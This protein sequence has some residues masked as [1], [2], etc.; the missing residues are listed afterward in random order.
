MAMKKR[1]FV[2][3][4]LVLVMSMV[5]TACS[6][7]GGGPDETTANNAGGTEQETT[8]KE[9]DITT[10]GTGT[11]SETKESTTKEEE[12]TQP[13]ECK[14][15]K[16]ELKNAKA[17]T[18]ID[19]G[20]SGDTVCTACG[21]V[22]SKGTELALSGH[23]Y[24]AGAILKEPTCLEKGSK[25][26]TCAV[27]K[28]TKT[29]EIAI[30]D[31][32][33][34]YHFESDSNHKLVC[35]FC[36]RTENGAHKNGGLVSKHE[37]T[38]D[39]EAYSVYKC[40]DCAHE[41]RV[42]DGP[43]KGH[44]WDTANPV[45][46]DPTCKD[47]G[48]M[49]FNCLNGC[50]EKGSV[51]VLPATPTVHS[52][53][54]V[55]R[56]DATCTHEGEISLVCE[57]CDMPSIVAIPKIPHTYGDAAVVDG[58]SEKTCKSC[59]HKV[60]SFDAK[61]KTDAKV[62]T[63]KL[64][65]DQAF[66]VELK[67]AQIEFPKEIVEQL[68]ENADVTVGA[69]FADKSS[70]LQSG[71]Y[72]ED[73][74]K[75][76][77]NEKSKIYDFTVDGIDTSDFAK[78]VT[79]TLPYTLGEN[80]DPE[81]IVIWY[82]DTSGEIV[83]VE[84][85]SFID[86]DGDGVGEVMFEVGHFSYYAIAYRE[87]PEMRCRRGV[88][89]YG[90]EKDWTIIP[91]S[92]ISHGYTVKTCGT[93]GHTNVDNVK[94][95]IAHNW[96]EKITPVVDCE[97]GGYVHQVCSM[98]YSVK[99]YEYI[100][101]KGHTPAGHAT[102]DT[103]VFCST[104]NKTIVSAYG[105]K[106]TEWETIIEPGNGTYG[107]RRRN[108]TRCGKIEQED[109]APKTD[110]KPWELNS[111]SDLIEV[112]LDEVIAED[113]GTITAKI[114][115]QGAEF[116]INV[117]FDKSG[118]K[119]KAVI[120]IDNSETKMTFYYFDGDFYIAN[121]EETIVTDINGMTSVSFED[122]MKTVGLAIDAVDGVYQDV[123]DGL[124]SFVEIL[125]GAY[126]EEIDKILADSG[127]KY[128]SESLAEAVEAI[129]SVY[130]Y[131][132]IKLGFETNVMLPAQPDADTLKAVLDAFM[133]AEK[134]NGGVKYTLS[135]DEILS[136]ANSVVKY[137]KDNSNK[138]LADM[139][140]VVAGDAIK[141]AKPEIKDWAALL[142]YLKTEYNG[143]TKVKK[144]VDSLSG[145]IA[146]SGEYT[147]D[148]VYAA[149]EEMLLEYLG[150][151]I[152][153]KTEV[154]KF[155]NKTLDS[156]IS[157]L[158]NNE[159]YTM[160][161]FY[162][163]L[164]DEMTKT[165]LGDIIVSSSV[166][167]E[168]VDG[169]WIETRYDTTVSDLIKQAEQILSSIKVTGSLSVSVSDKGG[170]LGI[171]FNMTFDRT[172]ENN[173]IDMTAS[174]SFK[175]DS[176][177][178]VVIPDNIKKLSDIN[179]NADYNEKGDLIISGAPAGAEI[180]GQGSGHIAIEDAVVYD[181]KFSEQLGLNVYMLKE[182]YWTTSTHIGRYAM[183][184]SGNLYVL[185]Y[186][187]HYIVQKVKVDEAIANCE[188]YLPDASSRCIGYV[189][190][191]FEN[192][193]KLYKTIFG[194]VYQ[195]DGVWML[196]NL[197]GKHS[198]G[199]GWD[200]EYGNYKYYREEDITSYPYITSISTMVLSNVVSDG[201]T[202]VD[203][204]GSTKYDIKRLNFT[205]DGVK[206]SVGFD[207][208]LIG[209]ELYFILN[210][211]SNLQSIYDL[212]EKVN[213]SY[214]ESYVEDSGES[215]IYENGRPTDKYT[216]ISLYKN[217]ASYY[218]EYDGKYFELETD[219]LMGQVL[220]LSVPFEKNPDLGECKPETLPDGRTIYVVG[221]SGS[222]E[223]QAMVYGYINVKDDLYVQTCLVYSEGELSDILY[224]QH[225]RHSN[226]VAADTKYI[227][228]DALTAIIT[229]NMVYQNGKYTIPAE[230][231]EMIKALCTDEFDT[232]SIRVVVSGEGYRYM[233]CIPVYCKLPESLS[234]SAGV[235]TQDTMG[236]DWY[237]YFQ[238]NGGSEMDE[239]DVN[240]NDDGSITVTD[241]DGEPVDFLIDTDYDKVIPG[242]GLVT[243][244]PSLND[245]YNKYYSA[246]ADQR[247]QDTYVQ[248]GGT[249]YNYNVNHKNIVKQYMS[250]K[251]PTSHIKA[252]CNIRDIYYEMDEIDIATGA[253]TGRIYRANVYVYANCY[254]SSQ[255]DIHMIYQNGNFYVLTDFEIEGE[256]V[257]VYNNKVLL[258]TYMKSLTATISAKSSEG[259]TDFYL[260]NGKQLYSESV[261]VMYGDQ[262]LTNIRILFY[263][264]GA[265]KTY[266]EITEYEYQS[267]YYIGSRA[268]LPEGWVELSRETRSD[269]YR[270][271]DLV[272]GYWHSTYSET[273]IK[274]HNT[275][276]DS[277]YMY[278]YTV[279][280]YTFVNGIS[281]NYIPV[282]Y[283]N[284]VWYQKFDFGYD[285]ESGQSFA[286]V[287]DPI[288]NMDGNLLV[289]GDGSYVGNTVDGFDVYESQMIDFSEVNEITLADGR[290]MY[291]RNGMTE[292]YV[293]VGD[294]RY[295]FA[296]LHQNEDGSYDAYLPDYKVD[297]YA[298]LNEEH[299]VGSLKL[300]DYITFDGESMTIDSDILEVLKPYEEYIER[301]I[302]RCGEYG[303]CNID[304]GTF[305]SWFEK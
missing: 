241:P 50:G 299:L 177:A 264:T 193:Y 21:K 32:S 128:T 149:I 250:Y 146:E 151:D 116:L 29:E 94:N 160:A 294:E 199:G 42:I 30:V 176:K 276:I 24:G 261:D 15:T 44:K 43:A 105:H 56:V 65:Q 275:Y 304:Y 206:N 300:R 211:D 280:R 11:Q 283:C 45:R 114:P 248:L 99:N 256:S 113:K 91:P 194:E 54:E 289:P 272:S 10:E 92:C 209:S 202:V 287:S 49:Y 295:M 110:I 210:T 64:N 126:G 62:N 191:S 111:M 227:Y 136:A 236:P 277:D 195:K 141:E 36:H 120:A 235:G 138:T 51:V 190:E 71:K 269:G 178:E 142:N 20:Y 67:D 60:S 196:I 14:H 286:I 291:V 25:I 85:V 31:C 305:L 8:S 292:G 5:L 171:E 260:A 163:D 258:D 46:V 203:T 290:K 185:N 159:K 215:I 274:I 6:W 7:F 80:E 198:Y 86:P 148:D 245:G 285:T 218:V 252:H 34:E 139:V 97:N 281:G 208:I 201:G 247:H 254:S 302:I 183:D 184:A 181:E 156:L 301:I 224:R 118:D 268:T 271:F 129:Q 17:S 200:S 230:T 288:E 265:Q 82:L 221:E 124:N 75:V 266:I 173:T 33:Y 150:R 182:E 223:Y 207:G 192:G 169:E 18:C 72:N 174:I 125:N 204:D 154:D 273:F 253:I 104:C 220:T 170:L 107:L 76:L 83:A 102:C 179:I 48:E 187:K 19:K 157:S 95:M 259:T 147:I 172:P 119:T 228:D 2:F 13:Q 152:D 249:Y 26:Y 166:N 155:S 28:E 188:K 12:T 84:N 90:E 145:A 225:Y 27:C 242:D 55:E 189:G 234:V 144:F 238:D 257:L 162:S 87:T 100:P 93:C 217:V 132:V 22:I 239:I 153:L 233:T 74:K 112:I 168:Y 123:F 103:A 205:V 4:V 216:I 122:I 251:D 101:S 61:D 240:K 88:H 243:Y 140:F 303:D 63:E 219:R 41:Y 137:F 81:G 226:S 70:I 47:E 40:T 262:V 52:Y 108:C 255:F 165:K 213:I 298:R 237:S 9:E 197:E 267:N 69:G 279:D 293:V 214:S 109:T 68:K 39:D 121:G 79:V 164:N 106:W 23:Q 66:K 143:N 246:I 212:G 296:M 89:D 127:S 297:Y 98:C 96:S 117:T 222:R 77:E 78:A 1:F 186:G 278:Y 158:A 130:A 115:A 134:V 167:Q 57:H 135:A 263:K 244:L 38:C 175:S 58:W 35:S 53:K 3:V 232:I 161:A 133:T 73:D 284:G 59:G 270:T 37:A 180:S 131:Y 282:Y 16:T 231:V 229:K